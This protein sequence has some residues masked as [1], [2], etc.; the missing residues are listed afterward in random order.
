MSDADNI[1]EAKEQAIKYL[2]SIRE[3]TLKVRASLK[4]CSNSRKKIL[5]KDKLYRCNERRKQFVYALRLAQQ[6]V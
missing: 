4:K 6:L 5:L 3:E 2:T 1:A